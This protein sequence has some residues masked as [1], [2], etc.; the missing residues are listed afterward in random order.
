MVDAFDRR[1]LVLL[2][3]AVVD[4]SFVVVDMDSSSDV[5]KNLY[6]EDLI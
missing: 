2:W 6:E 3:I 4:V 5:E 1:S